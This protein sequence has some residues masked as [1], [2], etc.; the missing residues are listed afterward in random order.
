MWENSVSCRFGHIYWGNIEWKTSFLCSLNSNAG[1][2]RNENVS[3]LFYAA[4]G[5]PFK[6]LLTIRS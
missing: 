6:A 3:D 1:K 4:I 2:Y 5:N